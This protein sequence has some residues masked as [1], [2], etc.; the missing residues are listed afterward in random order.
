MRGGGIPLGSQVWVWL[1]LEAF[2]D[3][4]KRPHEVE[5][6]QRVRAL[7]SFNQRWRDVRF[8]TFHMPFIV[9]AKELVT[10][11]IAKVVSRVDREYNQSGLEGFQIRLHLKQ[12]LIRAVSRN[13]AVQYLD[14]LGAVGV[15]DS[16]QARTKG[17][18]PS[19]V[20][21]RDK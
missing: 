15:E 3:S 9:E 5:T 11:E 7:E 4:C 13:A 18:L 14:W 16:L 17:V 8:V 20:F 2:R 21:S 6:W 12:R 19:A 10:S 1:A